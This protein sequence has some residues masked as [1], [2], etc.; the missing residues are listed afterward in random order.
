MKSGIA[1]VILLFSMGSYN[2]SSAQ[3]SENEIGIRVFTL[4]NADAESTVLLLTQLFSNTPDDEASK[5][6]FSTENR[7]NSIVCSGLYGDL[8]VIADVLDRVDTRTSRENGQG[9]VAQNQVTV[10]QLKNVPV[11]DIRNTVTDWLVQR[12]QA[13][14]MANL[15]T[16]HI[17]SDVLSNSLLVSTTCDE[18][19]ALVTKV[20]TVLDK[21]PEAVC[22]AM[23]LSQTP[24]GVKKLLGQPKVLTLNDT[25]A[26]ITL[27]TE[28]DSF[29]FELTP[30]IIQD[31]PNELTSENETHVDGRIWVRLGEDGT[32]AIIEKK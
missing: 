2:E 12:D 15:R 8:K 22:I 13:P 30:S 17:A 28:L 31:E 4:E 23:K 26:S 7:T 32:P 21:R 29:T 1:L 3:Q 18:T 24:N 25:P 14:G 19:R 11:F 27:G 6:K 20:V 5:L 10:I 9:N 16:T